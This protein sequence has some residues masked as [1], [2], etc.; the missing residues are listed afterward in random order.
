LILKDY[1]AQWGYL[2]RLTPASLSRL[3]NDAL[4]RSVCRY[5]P[6]YKL[7]PNIGLQKCRVADAPDGLLVWVVLTPTG[8]SL[9]VLATARRI[10][11]QSLG[12]IDDR[13]RGGRARLRVLVKD[14]GELAALA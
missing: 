10:G 8:D 6:A 5:E 13:K 12:V 14:Q 2:E 9:A 1:V 4:V 3:R 7:S 11:A